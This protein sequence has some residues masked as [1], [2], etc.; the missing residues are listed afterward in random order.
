[1]VRNIAPS[2]SQKTLNDFFVFCGNITSL[3]IKQDVD[4]KYE[5]T[6]CALITFETEAAAKTAQL[7]SNA[8]I[9]D[10]PIVVEVAATTTDPNPPPL[11]QA[12]QAR[13][14]QAGQGTLLD[15]FIATGNDVTVGVISKVKEL[16]EQT[17]VSQKVDSGLVA[18]KTT[19]A[20]IDA[21]YAISDKA[22]IVGATITTTLQGVNQNYKI[23]EN[24]NNFVSSA[25]ETT[26]TVAL[27]A[28]VAVD[29]ILETPQVSEGIKTVKNVT[30]TLGAAIGQQLASLFN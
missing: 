22:K 9:N 25:S 4:P 21:D 1:M 27:S 11:A 29:Q 26:A 28:K 10:R 6:L 8:L 17:G 23:E 12:A 5:G 15:S 24:F 7:L 14:A 30:E 3:N 19:V 2:T 16:D 20:K 13:P 18:V